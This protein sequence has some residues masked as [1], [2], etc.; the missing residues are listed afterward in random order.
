MN[1]G[2]NGEDKIRARNMSEM[3]YLYNQTKVVFVQACK[4]T[5]RYMKSSKSLKH[6]KLYL[7]YDHYGANH[8]SHHHQ[9]V[10]R[11]NCH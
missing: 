11:E 10:T 7:V 8:T 9:F 5:N 1:M 2:F 6:S 4:N 3:R